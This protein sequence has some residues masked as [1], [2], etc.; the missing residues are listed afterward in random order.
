MKTRSETLLS[1]MSLTMQSATGIWR[2]QSDEEEE[3]DLNFERWEIPP[4][5]ITKKNEK[6]EAPNK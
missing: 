1:S 4:P 6:K 5:I 3:E 2:P